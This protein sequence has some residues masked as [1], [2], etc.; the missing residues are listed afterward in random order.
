MT[1]RRRTRDKEATRARLLSAG[2]D[3]VYAHGFQ[4]ASVDRILKRLALTKGAFFHH[5]PSKLAFGYVLVDETIAG[6]IR[7]QWVQPLA[8]SDDPLATIGDAFESG[9]AALEGAPLNLGC[10][11]NNLAQEMSPLDDG[12]RLR[13]Q[14]VFELWMQ[15]YELALRRGQSAGTVGATVDARAE[16]F[17]LVAQIEGILSLAKN[18]QD[19]R[20]LRLGLANLRAHLNSLRPAAPTRIRPSSGGPRRR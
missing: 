17:A 4:A 20:A 19:R 14:Q 9:V 10:P 6:M 2:F 5:F 16:A 7:A 1:L 18:S 3:E 12:F 13:T 15:T 8:V 11:L